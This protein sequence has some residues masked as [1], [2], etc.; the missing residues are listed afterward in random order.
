MKQIAIDQPSYKFGPAAFKGVREQTEEILAGTPLFSRVDPDILKALAARARLSTFKKH[1][2]AVSEGCSKR[3]IGFVV[4][5]LFICRRSS[6][7]GLVFAFQHARPGTFFC[8]LSLI[9]S[10][11]SGVEVVAASSSATALM[12]AA[13]D[14]RQLMAQYPVISGLMVDELAER[15]NSL[16]EL[17][18]ELATMKIDARLRKTIGKLAREVG[19][20]RNNGVIDPAPTHAE[21]ATM[22]GTTREVV[23]RSVTALCRDGLIETRRQSILIRCV[24]A[25][26]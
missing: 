4:S 15:I 18:F 24:D 14:F 11:Y 2:T 10:D 8:E 22:L 23:S 20:L 25:F 21:L 16:S 13:D 26:E 5:G 3:M 19:Q 7:A 6:P 12:F 1:E 17:S 9:N